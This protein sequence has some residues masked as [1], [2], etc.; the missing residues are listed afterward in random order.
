MLLWTPIEELASSGCYSLAPIRVLWVLAKEQ[1]IAFLMH[2][3]E[4]R[5][6]ILP[7][8]REIIGF[9]KKQSKL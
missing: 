4:Y 5:C 8:A 2:N 7:D 6:L 1:N 3:W 9:R